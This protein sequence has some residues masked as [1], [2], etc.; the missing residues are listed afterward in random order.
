[1]QK[2][3]SN[4]SSDQ[5]TA[6]AFATSW[7]TLPAGSIYT[8]EQFEDWLNPLTKKDIENKSVLELGCGNGSLLVHITRW[9]PSKLEGVELG[10][11]IRSAY[12]N[13]VATGF[14]NAKITK[15]DL[16]TF[17]SDGFD[18][19]YCI[20]VIHHL[21]NPKEGFDAVLRNVKKG[22]RFHCWVYAKEGNAVIMYIVDPIRKLVS[23]LPWWFTKYFVA[24][25]LVVPY[26][27][28]AKLISLFRNISFVKQLPLYE[29]SCWI[30]QRE[31]LFFRHIAFDQ[32]VTPHTIY[33]EKTTI[34]KWLDSNPTI[35][36]ASTSI[37]FRNGNS[38]KF[39][40]KVVDY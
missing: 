22:G 1:M 24:T 17:E 38:W 30:A 10:D 36:P 7:N 16:T 13:I 4:T 32:L 34:Q 40:G 14:K 3:T 33:I 8:Y 6:D 18:I 11:S 27:V 21:K 26:Y 25:P 19:V 12:K 29:Y 23:K 37:I 31:F 9:N 5:K 28:Y 15:H 39:G 35:D 20:G 2:L